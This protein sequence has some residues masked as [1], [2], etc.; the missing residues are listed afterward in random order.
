MDMVNTSGGID[1]ARQK[2]EENLQKAFQILETL[3]DNS[4]RKSLKDLVQFTIDREN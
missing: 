2:M 4:W 1:Y 3:P